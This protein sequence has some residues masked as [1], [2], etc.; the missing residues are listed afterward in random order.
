[1]FD[2]V[3]ELIASVD[4]H[5]ESIICQLGFITEGVVTTHK[6][7]KAQ[8]LYCEGG[9]V[10]VNTKDKTYY[11]PSRHYIWIA[12]NEEQYILTSS[13]KVLIRVLYFPVTEEN[14]YTT[15]TKIYP[16]NE[17]LLGLMVHISNYSK[18]IFPSDVEDFTIAQSFYILLKRFSD[19]S[20]SLSLPFSS[21]EKMMDIIAHLNEHLSTKITLA[22]IAQK[23]NISQ[24]SITRLFSNELNMTFIE[25]LTIL[26]ILKSLE[27]LL[28]SKKSISEICFSVGYNS[29]PTFSNVFQKLIG[30][31]PVEY[32][33]AKKQL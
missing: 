2:N 8:F 30:M 15:N 28:E 12:P 13:D 6:H 1:M 24:R 18:E 10:Y 33:K 32:R 3:N 4:I 7:Q 19:F 25:Y 22:S 23:F 31:R 26:R 9:I 16:I 20:L 27:L 17:L 14:S 5:P 29:V 11:L 21:D